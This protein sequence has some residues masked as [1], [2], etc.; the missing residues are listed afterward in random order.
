[1]ADADDHVAGDHVAAS[2][3]DADPSPLVDAVA[4]DHV[5]AAGTD[6]G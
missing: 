2:L 6:C 4:G 5:P 1:M 3:V